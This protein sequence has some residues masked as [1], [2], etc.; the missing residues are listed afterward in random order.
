LVALTSERRLTQMSAPKLDRRRHLIAYRLKGTEMATV[1]FESATRIYAKS[2]RRAVDR[3][4]LELADG[5][6]LVLIGPSGCGKTTS[7][8]MLAGL[9]HVDAGTIRIDGEGEIETLRW[10]SRATP[11]IRI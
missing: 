5:E 8:R 7:L 1:S 4:D 2:D 10:S 11:S 9:E 6:F 3:L